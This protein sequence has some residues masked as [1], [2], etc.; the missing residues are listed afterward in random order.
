MKTRAQA[1]NEWFH[2]LKSWKEEPRPDIGE[3]FRA[4]WQA[5]EKETDKSSQWI[6]AQLLSGR[7]VVALISP[8][9]APQGPRYAGYYCE[10]YDD[11]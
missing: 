10:D 3:A 2:G 11:N 9:K 5:H 7:K 4:G 8:D 1:F 6:R